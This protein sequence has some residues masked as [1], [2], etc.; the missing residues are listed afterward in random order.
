MSMEAKRCGC[1]E[2]YREGFCTACEGTGQIP[3]PKAE[4]GHGRILCCDRCGIGP[5]RFQPSPDAGPYF[6]CSKCGEPVP[7]HSNG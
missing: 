3:P 5:C 1:P 7:S 2:Q 4:P 6:R